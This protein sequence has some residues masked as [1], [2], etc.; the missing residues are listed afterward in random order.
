MPLALPSTRIIAPVALLALAGCKFGWSDTGEDTD[1]NAVKTRSYDYE[2]SSMLLSDNGKQGIISTSAGVVVFDTT[3]G[4]ATATTPADDFAQPNLEDWV[5]DKVAIIDRNTDGGVFLWQPGELGYELREDDE[6]ANASHALGFDGGLA[7]V[8][9]R[10]KN[11]R[12]NREGLEL[13]ALQPC[14]FIRDVDIATDGTLFLGYDDDAKWTGVLRID[15]DGAEARLDVP[16]DIIAW[17]NVRNVLFTAT[18]DTTRV[19]AV[20]ADGGPVFSVDLPGA[21]TDLAALEAE[22]LLAVLAVQ[23]SDAY[24]HIIDQYSGNEV[25]TI[26]AAPA[27][28]S[29]AVSAD[30]S[31]LSIIQNERMAIV[32][33]DWDKLLTADTGT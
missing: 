13:V 7:W 14:G 24:V 32:T 12:I 26:E 29:L 33:V 2:A 3:T 8:G 27:S 9:R 30:S 5:G 20:T 6:G 23:G 31:T 11:C 22:G 10:A 15:P 4:D 17:D 18:A 28:T 25:A 16:M 19:E 21:V 1:D